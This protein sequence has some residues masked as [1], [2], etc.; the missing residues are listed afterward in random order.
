MRSFRQHEAR[1]HTQHCLPTQTHT[2]LSLSLTHT[3]T[4]ITPCST[5]ERSSLVQEKK[6]ATFSNFPPFSLVGVVEGAVVV[7]VVVVRVQRQTWRR[8]VPEEGPLRRLHRPA[9]QM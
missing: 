6:Q 7:V 2:A 1:T 8:T 3:R 4:Y 5:L 9:T